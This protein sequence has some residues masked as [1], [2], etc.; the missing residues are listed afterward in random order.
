[1]SDSLGLAFDEEKL[2]VVALRRRPGSLRLLEAFS[3]AVDGDTGSTLRARL[4]ELRLR[5]RHVHVAISRRHAVVKIIELPAVAGGDLR[6]MVGFELERHLPFSPA[7]A[8]Y[9][10]QVLAA[11]PGQPVR[12]L[13]TAVERRPFERLRQLLREAGLAPRLLDVGIHAVARLAASRDRPGGRT[14]VVGGLA[15]VRVAPGDAE[16]AVTFGGRVVASRAVPLPGR[17]DAARRGRVLVQEIERTLNGLPAEERDA[18]RAIAVVG[19]DVLLPASPLPL[20]SRLRLPPGTPDVGV[21]AL[22]AL[23]VGLAR[24]R[25]GV[26]PANLVPD[27]LKPRPFP[28]A[29]VATAALAA[30]SLG[31]VA[32]RPAVSMFRHRQTL[33]RLDASLARLAP[34]ARRVSELQAQV[35]RARR[36]VEALRGFAGGSVPALPVLQELTELLPADVWLTAFSADRHGVELTGFAGSASQLIPLLEA[37][38]RLERVEF[39]SPVTKGRDR[40]Q[41]RLKAAWNRLGR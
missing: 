39:T 36:E 29:L 32:A 3:I 33:S 37:S 8:L 6:R 11:A 17:E 12:V 24:P 20:S 5:T 2:E 23:A 14:R 15:V 22:P 9:D 34:D 4:R 41:F 26:F 31:L 38:P 30:L 21:T 10:F 28:G 35:E 19:G 1:M 7:D 40:E 13:L 18:I 27:E 16:L 25:R